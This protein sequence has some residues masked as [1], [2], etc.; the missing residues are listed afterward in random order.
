MKFKDVPN[1]AFFSPADKPHRKLMKSP[2]TDIVLNEKL[3]MCG[4]FKD[5]VECILDETTGDIANVLQ[6]SNTR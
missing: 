1:G 6:P 2:E 5:D 3:E 4:V